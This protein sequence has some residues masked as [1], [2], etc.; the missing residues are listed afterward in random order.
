MGT[1]RFE[2]VNKNFGEVEVLKDL[3]IT[4]NE[5]ERLIL[6]GASGCGKSTVLRLIAGLEKVTSGSIYFN[7]TLVNNI[8]AGDRNVAMVFQNYALYPHMTVE[9]NITYALR[10]HKMI[11]SEI[12]ERL[13][14]AVNILR[15]NGLEK[16]KPR[17]L[18]GGQRQRVALARAVVKRS[19]YFLLDEPLS[20]LDAQLRQ[21]AR[22]ELLKIH[23]LFRCTFVYVTHDQIEAMTLGDRVALMH[24]GKL[25]MIDT[26]DN[27]FNKP[28]N[29]YTAKFIGTPACNTVSGKYDKG[30][31]WIGENQVLLPANWQRHIEKTGFTD[32]VLGLR[33]EHIT[34]S[35]DK[36]EYAING[37][38]TSAENYG[39]KK[40]VYFGLGE[41]EWIALTENKDF[42]VGDQLYFHFDTNKMHLFDL[43]STNSIGYPD[44]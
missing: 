25:Q 32:L 24:E 36:S 31:L 22:K 11:K 4:V 23:E 35:K 1:I 10:A 40:G 14:E 27:I 12:D 30:S 41:E 43:E 26:P 6:L 17:E 5:G 34:L 28:A 21:H 33:P 38:I 42:K 37:T 9:R 3:N 19:E 39:S 18:S 7:D 20:N 13:T 16:R 8:S 44:E 29:I 15:L 2:N